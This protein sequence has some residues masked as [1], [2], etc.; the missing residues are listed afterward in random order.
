M[1]FASV[2]ESEKRVLQVLLE[3]HEWSCDGVPDVASVHWLA[4]QTGL[5]AATCSKARKRLV[6]LGL[7]QEGE[8]KR[9]RGV[10]GSAA[11]TYKP[12]AA[13]VK[14]LTASIPGADADAD[15]PGEDAMT[16]EVLEQIRAL[17]EE[18][19]EFRRENTRAHEGQAA[20]IEERVHGSLWEQF[21][22]D[23]D[24]VYEDE[25]FE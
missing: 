4:E 22:E 14:Y 17:R 18:V 9:L 15:A 8:P 23:T 5:N 25:V 20:K 10:R 2:R 1:V 11:K 6:E 24:E 13:G 16:A 3:H 21:Y 19:A 12:T 7:L